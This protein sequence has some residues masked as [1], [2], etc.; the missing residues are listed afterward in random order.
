[1]LALV[2][3][4]MVVLAV[5]QILVRNVLGRGI[6][7]ADPLLR[8]AVLWLAFLGALY[9]T[10]EG[11][12]LSLDALPKTLSPA[13]A[14]VTHVVSQVTAAAASF[15]LGWA[16]LRLVVSESAAGTTSPVGVATWWL[17]LPM[18][19]ALGLMSL[20]FVVRMFRQPE[21]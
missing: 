3:L 17:Q 21:A 5:A 4:G 13:L 14:R 11:R 20:R 2:I 12:H 8:H 10:K 1:M 19:V 9:G 15:V 16:A 18:P 7:W 6:L